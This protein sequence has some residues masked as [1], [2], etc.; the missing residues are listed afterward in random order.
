[1]KPRKT[2]SSFSVRTEGPYIMITDED[3]G[4]S[5]TNDIENVIESVDEQLGHPIDEF[6]IIYKDSQGTVDGVQTKNG[7]FA[8]FYTIGARNFDDAKDKVKENFND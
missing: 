3:R 5:V 4:M 8:R 1:M 7:K 2:K 6:Y